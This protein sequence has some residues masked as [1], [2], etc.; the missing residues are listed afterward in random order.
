MRCE[1]KTQP[2]KIGQACKKTSKILEEWNGYPEFFLKLWKFL[3]IICFFDQ[4]F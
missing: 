2:P 4:L 3:G 1:I